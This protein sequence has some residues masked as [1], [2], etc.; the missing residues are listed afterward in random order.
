MALPDGLIVIAKRECPTC[1]LVEPLLARLG[2]GGDRV[3][4]LVQDD[5]AYA[6]GMPGAVFDST[7]EQSFRLGIEFVPTLIRMRGGR[8]VARTHGWHRGIGKTSAASPPW[9]PTCRRCAPAAP[10]RRWNRASPR[11][12]SCATAAPA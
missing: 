8:E 11:R 3:T 9:A 10:A 4:V 7:L 2:D 5:P 12:C 1:T 6:A